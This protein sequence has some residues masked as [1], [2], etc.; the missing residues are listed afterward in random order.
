M[1]SIRGKITAAI[2]LCSLITAS[3]IGFLSITNSRKLSNT[4][5][6]N[7]LVMTGTATTG[8]INSMITKIEHSVDTLSDIAL[9]RLDFNKFKSSPTYVDQYTNELKDDFFTFAEHTDG[10]IA[11]YIRFNPDF[12]APT[13]G[14]FL[15]RNDT[16]SPFSSVTPTDFSMY[17]PSDVAHVGWYY[18]PVENKAPIWMDPY[19]NE[20][21]NVYMISYVVPLYVD[22]VSVG[23]IGMDIDFGAL[24]SLAD[25]A[26]A[27]DSGYSFIVSSSGNV[28][29]HPS[30]ETGTALA[31]YEGGAL[32]KVTE[33]IGDSANQGHVTSYS[34]NGVKKDMSFTELKNGMKLLITAPQK[35]IQSAANS[36]SAKILVGLFVGFLVAA[37]L[38]F[39]IGGQ[40]AKPITHMTNIIKQTSQLNFTHTG[41]SQALMKHKDETGVMAKAIGDMREVLRELVGSMEQEKDNLVANMKQL[42]DVMGENNSIAVDNSAT[43]K[44]V[45]TAIQETVTSV[46]H[47]VENTDA[48]ARNAVDIQELSQK[49]QKESHNIMAR[50]RQLS[51]DTKASNEKAMSIYEDMKSRTEQAIERSKV[52]AKINELTDD[53]RNI[54]SQTNLLALNANIEAARAGDAGKGFAVVAT[55][56][57]ALANQTFQTVD[58]I[59]EIVEEVNETVQ[60]M[61]E[62]IRVIMNFLEETVVKDYASFGTIGEQYENDAAIFAESMQQIYTEISDL[63]IKI[64]EIAEAMDNVNKNVTESADGVNLIA[65]KSGKAVEK[66]TEGYEHLRV[67]SDSLNSLNALIEKFNI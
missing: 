37:T 50:A 51:E 55:E 20:N 39:L 32:T 28:L 53:I 41:K 21:I 58:G 35:E 16:E 49:E 27:F 65:D 29:H 12:T 61:T 66:T 6:E 42:D 47:V 1:R 2:V 18:I 4:A 7:E 63:N 57:G 56:I 13:S 19:L 52:V 62:C 3:F 45:A 24:T 11:A 15:T 17:D 38:G 9:S 26:T 48:I 34:L 31:E 46:S 64:N 67:S 54:S 8:D 22:G 10:T 59:N 25:A 23:I 33:F 40:I 30:I 60:N 36:L 14:L 43:T 5:A 44:Q